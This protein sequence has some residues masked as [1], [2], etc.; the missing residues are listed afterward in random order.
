[1]PIYDVKSKQFVTNQYLHSYTQKSHSRS[2]SLMGFLPP[3]LC[4]LTVSAAKC[5]DPLNS[6]N[7]FKKHNFKHYIQTSYQARRKYYYLPENMNSKFTEQQFS[8]WVL[9]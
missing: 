1:M 4:F 7:N 3:I 8:L 2:A 5:A 6:Y 9:E